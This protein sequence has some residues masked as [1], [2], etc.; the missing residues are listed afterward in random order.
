MSNKDEHWR[1]NYLQPK[2]KKWVIASMHYAIT[3]N[4]QLFFNLL[5]NHLKY[6]KSVQCHFKV[7]LKSEII[8][9]NGEFFKAIP[10]T[11]SELTLSQKRQ[12]I[13]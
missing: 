1:K 3:C 12:A 10:R 13:E 5:F 8:D 9:I 2:F 11:G 7:T 6:F 4:L